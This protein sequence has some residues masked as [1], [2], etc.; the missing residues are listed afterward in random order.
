[1]MNSNPLYR[2][3]GVAG[4]TTALVLGA[5]QIAAAAPIVDHVQ[6]V[7]SERAAKSSVGAP[8]SAKAVKNLRVTKDGAVVNAR[9][10]KGWIAVKADDVT[11]K[12]TTVLSSGKYSIRVFPGA[13]GTKVKS[14]RIKCQNTKTNGLVPGRYA[15]DKVYVSGCRTAFASSAENPATIVKSRVDGKPY[16]SEATTDGDRPNET[17]TGVPAG[18]ELRPSG[19]ITVTQDGAVVNARHVQG[20]I[21]IEADNVT[22]RNTLVQ[23]D[24]D[25]YPIHVDGDAQGALIEDVEIDNMGGTGIGILFSSGTSGTVRRA[26]IH[27]GEDGIR[28]QASNVSLEYS[29]IHDLHRQPNGHHD[30]VQIRSGDNITLLG[31]TLLAYNAET[32][33]PM[34][35]AIQIGS[36]VGDDQISNLRVIGNYMDGGSF[37]V[38]GGGRNE[39][40]SAIY[41]ENRFGRNSRYGVRGNLDNSVWERSNVWDDTGRYAH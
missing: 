41:S 28:I 32:N 13:T 16:S 22:V 37:T 6:H 25:G 31:N 24:S 17:N 33:D 27:S 34:N 14:T 18:T 10:V 39:V 7:Q 21:S 1:M 12:N 40:D 3:L 11:I 19:S 35:A 26:N 20:T 8:K 29:Y 2:R 15:A 38:N 23:S 9:V 5:V 4:L 36:L 30:A